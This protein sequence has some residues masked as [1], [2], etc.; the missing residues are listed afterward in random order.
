MNGVHDMGGMDGFGP[1][2]R[3][4]NEPVF[5]ADWERRVFALTLAMGGRRC[6]NV[7]ELR[8]TIERIPPA[9]YLAASYY[10]RWLE[11]V[12]ALLIEKGVIS[13]AELDAAMRAADNPRE[14]GPVPEAAVLVM[15]DDETSRRVSRDGARAR[16]ERPSKPLFKPGD[17]V[18]ARNMNPAGHTRIPRYVRGHRGVVKHDWGLFV[19]PDTHAHG[20]GTNPRHCYAIEFGAREL[21]GDGHSARDRIV[22]DLWEDYLERDPSRAASGVA[23][24]RT[25]KRAA[26]SSARKSKTAAK[27][28]SRR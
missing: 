27:S 19:F 3:E 14:P 11:A 7:D 4:D 20:L 10:E 23:G 5:H 24:T 26:P 15:P 25:L 9:R 22:I 2:P 13:A 1:I 6:Y 18:I 17:R 12:E 16:R 8:R 21:W 28:R